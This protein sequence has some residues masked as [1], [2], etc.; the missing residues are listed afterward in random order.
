MDQATSVLHE[1]LARPYLGMIWPPGLEPVPMLD[2]PFEPRV[3]I[4]RIILGSAGRERFTVLGQRGRVNGVEDQK[5]V[6]PERIDEWTTRRLQTDG[7]RPAA[8]A[9]AQ[10]GGPGL[11]LFRS[12]LE[13][14]G[15]LLASRDVNQT[16]IMLGV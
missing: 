15:L 12:V 3:R 14:Q 11:K 9:D 1:I 2:E 6:F 16:D 7:N 10:R 4:P 8:K 13:N 5:V